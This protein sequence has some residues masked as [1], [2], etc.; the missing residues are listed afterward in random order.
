MEESKEQPIPASQEENPSTFL[1]IEAL[2][3]ERGIEYVQTTVCNNL[4]MYDNFQHKP[5]F[6][7]KEAAEVRGVSLDSGAKAMLLRDNS[8]ESVETSVL[9]TLAVM[10][11]SK[12]FSWKLVKKVL[13]V[14]NMRFATPEEVQQVTGCLPG[15]VPPFGSVFGVQ[16]IVDES[17]YQQGE[18]INF[19]CGLRT[20]SMKLKVNDYLEIEKPKLISVFTEDGIEEQTEDKASNITE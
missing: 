13:K 12:K 6:T 2:L 5:V 14:K 1:K 9:F 17:L 7:S 20:H 8:S 11:A 4:F 19:N 10:S 15:A 16:T 18:T 3:K